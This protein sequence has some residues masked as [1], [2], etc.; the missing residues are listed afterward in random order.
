MLAITEGS[1]QDLIDLLKEDIMLFA[2]G[3]G[4]TS[5]SRANG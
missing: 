4:A 1:M 2:D 3:G 5:S